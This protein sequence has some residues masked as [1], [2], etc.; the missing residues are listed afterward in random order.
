MVKLATPVSHLFRE[1]AEAAR[2]IL[3]HTDVVEVRDRTWNYVSEKQELFHSDL[4][5]IHHFDEKI[6]NYFKKVK[7]CKKEL[8]LVTFHIASSCD[9]P[10]IE[11]KMW[12]VGGKKYSRDEMLI[13]AKYN[14]EKLRQIFGSDIQFAI[15]NNNYYP[16]EAYECVCDPAFISQLAKE[17]DL[18]FLFDIAHAKV[19]SINMKVDFESYISGLPM[20]RLIQIHICQYRVEDTGLAYDA[21]EPPEH[22]TYEVVRKLL[23][24][25]SLKYLTMEYYKD[26]PRLLTCLKELKEIASERH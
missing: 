14:F 20:D 3:D 12:Q 22:E 23:N 13:N 4:Q 6:W 17:N 24:E 26:L 1:S 7:E 18:F 11:G 5:P 2:L 19:S 10:I 9:A 21:H 25:K 16:T 8:K 15:E